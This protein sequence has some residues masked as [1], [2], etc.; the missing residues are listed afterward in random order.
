MV[1][2]EQIALAIEM[3]EPAYEDF[4]IGCKLRYEVADNFE[5]TYECTN[6]PECTAW[7]DNV[8]QMAR[9]DG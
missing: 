9:Q 4:C 5:I 2:I 8:M 7:N 6:Y 3:M 1:S